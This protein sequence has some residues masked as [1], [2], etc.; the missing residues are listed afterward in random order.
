MISHF[1]FHD[2]FSKAP[3]KIEPW[4]NEGAY[5]CPLGEKVP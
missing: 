3:S 1:V 4:K 2:Y 5:V